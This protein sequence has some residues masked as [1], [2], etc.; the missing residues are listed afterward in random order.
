MG[1]L[2]SAAEVLRLCRDA[3]LPILQASSP[4][5]SQCTWIAFKVDG[6]RLRAMKMT[7]KELAN[8]VADVVFNC[9][10][11]V[12]FHRIILVGED[13]DVHDDADI[14][15]AF[16][17]RCRPGL[18]EYPYEDVKG[19]ALIPYMAQGNGNPTKGGKMVC[20]A[21]FPVE[22]TT[23]RN[24]VNTS[25]HQGYPKLLQDKILASWETVGFRKL[26]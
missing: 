19:F 8:R 12:P 18:D 17:T 26:D 25:F 4:L 21:L 13:I 20:D 1:G 22:Y 5:I 16:S 10:A 14:I 2:A 11:G 6:T 23:G 24:W 15:W 3:D 7:P 9:K